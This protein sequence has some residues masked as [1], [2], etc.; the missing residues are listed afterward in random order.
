MAVAVAVLLAVA[1]MERTSP[2]R[3]SMSVSVASVIAPASPEKKAE[4][5]DSWRP[6]RVVVA[7]FVVAVAT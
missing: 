2:A 4:A 1:P 6:M 5:D 7:A 3:M